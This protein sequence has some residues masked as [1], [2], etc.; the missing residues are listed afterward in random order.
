MKTSSCFTARVSYCESKPSSWSNMRRPRT[1]FELTRQ[2]WL[3]LVMF[4]TR[5]PE[6]RFDSYSPPSRISAYGVRVC[7]SL[8]QCT[9]CVGAPQV[10]CTHTPTKPEVREAR[11][12]SH[13]I[14]SHPHMGGCVSVQ[15]RVHT[16]VYVCARLQS[17][18]PTNIPLGVSSAG[19]RSNEHASQK[20]AVLACG[21]RLW[22]AATRML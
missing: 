16:R 2:A 19:A 5:S 15:A 7:A 21:S 17:Y 12:P 9:R 4:G 20:G 14:H 8:A 18:R 1:M 6:P 10:T 3:C 22:R 11:G 13:T